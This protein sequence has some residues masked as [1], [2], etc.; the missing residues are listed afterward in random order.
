[1]KQNLKKNNKQYADLIMKCRDNPECFH[2]EDANDDGKDDG[3]NEYDSVP[4]NNHGGSQNE[5]PWK[6]IDKKDNY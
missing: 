5:E 2:K 1:M 6:L 4:D 3:D